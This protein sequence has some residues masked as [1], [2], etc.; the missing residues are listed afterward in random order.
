VLLDRRTFESAW[1]RFDGSTL[2]LSIRH[3][4]LVMDIAVWI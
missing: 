1:T 2:T 3:A 4:G